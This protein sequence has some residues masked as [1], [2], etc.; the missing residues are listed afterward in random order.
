MFVGIFVFSIGVLLSMRF[1]WYYFFGNGTS[2]I[3]S[4]IL[5]AVL[6]LIGFQTMLSAFMVDLLA[7]NRKLAEDILYRMRWMEYSGKK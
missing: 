1:L 5:T 2:H 6:L 7:A 3:Q 4:F